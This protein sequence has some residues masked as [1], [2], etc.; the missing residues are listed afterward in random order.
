MSLMSNYALFLSL[1]EAKK[2]IPSS[3]RYKKVNGTHTGV[4]WSAD[5]YIPTVQL[6]YR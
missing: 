4:A 2:V 5:E 3:V 1:V 6:L